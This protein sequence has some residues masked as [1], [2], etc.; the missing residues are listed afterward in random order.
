[1]RTAQLP[2]LQ[3]KRKLLQVR[4]LRD[5]HRAGW[6]ELDQE[7]WKAAKGVTY[8]LGEWGLISIFNRPVQQSI[9]QLAPPSSPETLIL[10]R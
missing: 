6:A 5:C 9:L 2:R 8:N 7:P 1:M 3:L 4:S 10:S